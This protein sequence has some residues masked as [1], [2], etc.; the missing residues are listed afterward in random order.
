MEPAIYMNMALSLNAIPTYGPYWDMIIPTQTEYVAILRLYKMVTPTN[1][2]DGYRIQYWRFGIPHKAVYFRCSQGIG[3]G[4]VAAAYDYNTIWSTT[5]SN[6]AGRGTRWTPGASVAG[7]THLA[8][9]YLSRTDTGILSV[10]RTEDDP[11]GSPTWTNIG[12]INT[13]TQTTADPTWNTLISGGNINYD[14][15]AVAKFTLATPL[16]SS[17]TIRVIYSSGTWPRASWIAPYWNGVRPTG[18]E[19][20]IFTDLVHPEAASIDEAF[21]AVE[22][23][24]DGVGTNW[25]GSYNHSTVATGNAV[26]AG[27]TPVITCNGTTYNPAVPGYVPKF[28]SLVQSGTVKT[29]TY[30][31]LGTLLE[32]YTPVTNGLTIVHKFSRPASPTPATVKLIESYLGAWYGRDETTKVI[33]SNGTTATLSGTSATSNYPLSAGFDN[34]AWVKI[35]S[36]EIPVHVLL[37]PYA[38]DASNPDYIDRII[39]VGATGAGM[40]AR[41]YLSP[42]TTEATLPANAWRQIGLKYQFLDKN[43]ARHSINPFGLLKGQLALFFG[44]E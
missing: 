2:T 40:M 3:V 19:H 12:T 38:I 27:G 4:G 35:T 41:P 29:T 21:D 16:T 9:G 39:S 14:L 25:M 20:A 44:E 36:D 24:N 10:D 26:M 13:T 22:N 33:S 30:S 1:A 23:L 6:S 32:T 7:A 8:V 37:T 31:N 15:E 5:G 11:A 42:R 17:T 34:S 43:P 28:E 18:T